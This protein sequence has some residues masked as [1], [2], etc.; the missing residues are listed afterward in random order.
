MDIAIGEIIILLAAIFLLFIYLYNEKK[1]KYNAEQQEIEEGKE[2]EQ[3][4]V[5][6]QNKE[7]EN[8]DD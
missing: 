7:I 5:I 3:N 4:K 1:F 2:I 8:K 6:E